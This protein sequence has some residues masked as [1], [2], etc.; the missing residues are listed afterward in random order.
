MDSLPIYLDNQSTT[1]VDPR[2][3]EAMLPFFREIY[4]NPSTSNPSGR[5]SR[6]AVEEAREQ[7]A[8][9][10]DCQENEIY[11]TSGAT[12]ALNWAIRSTI[13]NAPK[14][15][16]QIVTSSIEHS[17]VIRTCEYF[18]NRGHVELF[19]VKP[20]ISGIVNLDDF[21]SAIGSN[22]L[23]VVLQHANNE[24]GTIQPIRE[25]GEYCRNKGITFLVDAA[26]SLGKIPCKLSEIPVDMLA[27]SGHKIYGPKG[28]GFLYINKEIKANVNPILFGGAQEKSMRAGT[29]N[30]PSVVGLG[31]ACRLC[32]FEI[33]EESERITSLR[34]KLI[35]NLQMMVPTIGINGSL[36]NRLPGSLNFSVP[37]IESWML[38]KNL[39]DIVIS[40]GA[41]CNSLSETLSHVICSI[42]N[43]ESIAKSAFRIGLGRFNTLNEVQYASE[44]IGFTINEI[45]LAKK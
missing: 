8:K 4:G 45:L 2:V 14:F 28:V 10:L 12:E 41:A 34:N 38:L 20:G 22:T 33:Q 21:K 43:D 27:G 19:K 40:R 3:L 1:Q 15:K 25:I 6:L 11:F 17:A 24:I 32:E 9:L 31:E 36:I 29:E 42:T 26:Q 18:Q 16:N 13:E 30:V 39:P 37:G 5:K 44:K 35:T 23:L 7:V